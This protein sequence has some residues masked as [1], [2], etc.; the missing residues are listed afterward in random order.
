M[1]SRPHNQPPRTAATRKTGRPSQAERRLGER[2]RSVEIL[3][4]ERTLESLLQN[5]PDAVIR[6]DREGRHIYANPAC[7]KVLGVPAEEMIGKTAQEL[8][9]AVN[10]RRKWASR[11]ARVVASGKARSLQDVFEGPRG[12]VRHEVKLVPELDEHGEVATVLIVV[13]D[14]GERHRAERSLQESEERFRVTFEQAP[15]AMLLIDRDAHIRGANPAA[16]KLL[17]YSLE[18]LAEKT[19]YDITHPDDI[20][21][22]QDVAE[23]IYDR[24]ET[25]VSVEKRYLRK[26]GEIVWG[27]LS[28]S[29]VRDPERG[30][31]NNIAQIVDIT[32]LKLAERALRE[33]E[34]LQRVVTEQATDVIAVI[35]FD[36]SIRLISQSV[37]NALGYEPEELIGH[38][39]EELLDPA[40]MSG[41]RADIEG[42]IGGAAPA[43]REFRLRHRNGEWRL[44]E[45]I[46]SIARGEDGAPEYVIT[47][48]RDVTERTQLERQL[49]VAQR[50]EAVGQLAGG[51]AHDFNN[52]LT[53]INGFADLSLKA[54]DG[55]E[56]TVRQYLSEI[57]GAGQ[58]AAELTQHLLAFSRQ[59]V[60]Q[61]EVLD[62]NAVVEEYV[63][64]L[65]R[66]LGEEVELVAR[67]APDLYRVEV[68]PG[69]L[70]QVLTNLAV[71][72]RDAMPSGGAVTISTENV[73]LEQAL[74]L[75]HGSLARGSYV[76]LSV[77]DAGEGIAL[78]AREHVFE[79][80]FT[81]KEPGQGTGLGLATVLGI[82]EQSGGAVTF[83]SEP[84]KGTTFHI[85]LP[86][87]KAATSAK[88]VRAESVQNGAGTILV[89]EDDDAVR[90]L[91]AKIL[92]EA[93]YRVLVSSS[94]REA[95]ALANWEPSIDVLVTDVVMPEMNGHEMAQRLL[96]LRPDLRVLY[97]SGYTPDV[98]RARGVVAQ[99]EAFLQKPFTAAVLTQ[100]V[101]DLTAG[102]T[103]DD[104][105]PAKS[106][107][108]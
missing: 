63:G 13:H 50:M 72:A 14:F 60:L 83:S 39:V 21:L 26:D 106:E 36:F 91:V 20:E 27:R 78:E 43:S 107:K 46:G 65:G 52:L 57:G 69:Q 38:G 40:L 44:F 105:P 94:A 47:I 24:D 49:L 75:T 56:E 98:V 31:I 87:S 7:V 66:M 79:P 55:R 37:R 8:P 51:V 68:D 67:L 80:F 93:G 35:G 18:E 108:N 25:S 34:E 90:K 89:V 42:V 4:R 74:P 3:E 22:T 97:I 82:V 11:V 1:S 84:R 102:S 103:T 88:P 86:R 12:T 85:Y 76:V 9:I 77:A 59:Q 28:V 101:R 53:V 33:R 81:T 104:Q 15:I 64:M 73:E 48:L 5:L 71:N 96:A 19:I 17:G 29:A 58:R 45:G 62:L 41:I 61:P 6:V 10:L 70:G 95:L 100:T 54:L 92:L 16:N 99:Q 2:R 23:R 30:L 32:Q